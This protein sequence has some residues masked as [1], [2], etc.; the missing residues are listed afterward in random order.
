MSASRPADAWA[1]ADAAWAEVRR[2]VG[3][4]PV[5]L[6]ALEEL[7]PVWNGGVGTL[8]EVMRQTRAVDDLVKEMGPVVSR[9]KRRV[10]PLAE[11]GAA[12]GAKLS[13]EAA[14]PA[15]G[16][17]TMVPSFIQVFELLERHADRVRRHYQPTTGGAREHPSK[18]VGP[19]ERLA[20]TLPVARRITSPTG[21]ALYEI[22]TG[23][24]RPCTTAA[25]FD[26][27]MERWK[28]NRKRWRQGGHST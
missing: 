3:G 4:D 13:P 20:D 11:A 19:L 5:V 28:K 27:R 23:R 24:D 17:A 25:G 18:L 10:Q 14:D 9:L 22:A 26:R 21:L 7:A 6:L 2:L 16:L 15:V 1:S 8:L 12:F